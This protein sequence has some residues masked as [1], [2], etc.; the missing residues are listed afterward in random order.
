[1]DGSGGYKGKAEGSNSSEGL[2]IAN[3]T[4][5]PLDKA[6]E[7]CIRDSLITENNPYFC[8]ESFTKDK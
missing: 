3:L 7:M 6:S 4:G 8:H 5:E 1:M 2:W